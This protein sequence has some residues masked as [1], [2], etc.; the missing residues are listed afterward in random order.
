MYILGRELIRQLA[1]LGMAV[2]DAPLV[3]QGG[4]RHQTCALRLARTSVLR[5]L[6]YSP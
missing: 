2:R 4:A 5:A 6:A 1:E 3:E